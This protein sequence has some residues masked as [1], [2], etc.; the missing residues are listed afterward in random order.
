V[1]QQEAMAFSFNSS[2]QPT[3]CKPNPSD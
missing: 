1:K 2:L 3:P